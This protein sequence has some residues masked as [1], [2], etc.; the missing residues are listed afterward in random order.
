MSQYASNI[1]DE[2]QLERL[3]IAMHAV[4]GIKLTQQPNAPLHR[5]ARYRGTVVNV[6]K[7]TRNNSVKVYLQGVD[8]P[9]LRM[10]FEEIQKQ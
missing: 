8:S 5:L 7:N 1:L 10:L 2:R 4:Y 9:L 3:E 6:W